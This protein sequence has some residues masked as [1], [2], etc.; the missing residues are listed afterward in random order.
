MMIQILNGLVYGGLL[1]ILSLGLVLLF[2][3][4]RVV[5]FAHGAL[6]MVGAYVGY[7]A[8]S[9]TNYWIALVGAMIILAVLGALL[10][11]FV[12]RPLQKEDPLVTVLVT[13]GLLILLEHA[14]LIIWGKDF[15]SLPV[16]AIL[17]GTVR[18]Q[19]EEFPLYRLF[20]IGVAAAVALGMSL[21]L[22]LSRVGLYV[23]A[24]S[25][26]PLTTGILGVKTDRIS[27]G[28]VALGT[29]LAGLAGMVAAPLLAIS[30]SMGSYILIESFIVVVIGGLGSFTGAFFAALLVGQIY[31]FGAV[32]MPWAASI[33][34]FLI[35]VVI[36]IWKPTGMAGKHV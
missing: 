24:S 31:N 16:P 10:D 28:V 9:I 8:A 23:R 36:L 19:G 20:V 30:P 14:A 12:L 21:W 1:Y 22:K 32:Y 34:P 17:D 11:V 3:L 4:R 13:F 35:M 25:V 18:L 5:N 29:S 27:I 26:D 6:F 15:R 7:T 2:G 33:I